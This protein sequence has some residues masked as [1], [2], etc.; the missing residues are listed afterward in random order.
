M[1]DAA[2][3]A[4]LDGAEGGRRIQIAGRLTLGR[5]DDADLFIDDP[6]IS[7]AHAVFG[8]DGRKGSRSRTS[9]R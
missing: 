2:F 6:E 7:R 1:R 3:V 9:G 8:L 5:G 4:V